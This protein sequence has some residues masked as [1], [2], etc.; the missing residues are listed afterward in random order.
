MRETHHGSYL[1]SQKPCEKK[2]LHIYQN[3]FESQTF[4][5][6]QIDF[7]AY[8]KNIIFIKHKKPFNQILSLSLFDRSFKPSKD[9]PPYAY[10]PPSSPSD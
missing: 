5:T 1:R 9:L 10:P 2:Y 7:K 4:S 8:E 3:W 6:P